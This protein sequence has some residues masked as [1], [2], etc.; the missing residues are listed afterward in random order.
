MATWKRLALRPLQTAAPSKALLELAALEENRL[1][2]EE[3]RE[4]HEMRVPAQR[5]QLLGL[6]RGRV[7]TQ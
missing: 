4:P 5:G 7:E 6:E 2:G 3:L 1:T